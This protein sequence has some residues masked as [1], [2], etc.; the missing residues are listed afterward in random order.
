[1][2]RTLHHI[3]CFSGQNNQKGNA[4]SEEDKPGNDQRGRDSA[5]V[6]PGWAR[7]RARGCNM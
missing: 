7:F 3:A 5:T 6:G 2:T 1:M 4:R